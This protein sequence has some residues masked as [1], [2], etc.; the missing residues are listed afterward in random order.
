[1][2]NEVELNGFDVPETNTAINAADLT[3][4]KRKIG[5]KRIKRVEGGMTKCLYFPTIYSSF[6]SVSLTLQYI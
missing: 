5:M 1:M 6:S 2:K 4:P 3:E